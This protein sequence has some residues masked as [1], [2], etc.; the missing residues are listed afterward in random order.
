MEENELEELMKGPGE[1]QK[2]IALMVELALRRGGS[3][4][5]TVLVAVADG[6]AV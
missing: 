5:I 3:D 6:G 1:W 4:N 2:K